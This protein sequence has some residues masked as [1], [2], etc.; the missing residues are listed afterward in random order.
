M[1]NLPASYQGVAFNEVPES[2][3]QIHGDDVAA[4]FGFEGGLVPGVT[5]SAYLAHPA[6][7]AWNPQ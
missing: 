4:R 7:M 6:V 5:V 2:E 1:M 3:S